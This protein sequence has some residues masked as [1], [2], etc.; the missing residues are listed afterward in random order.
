VSRALRGFDSVDPVIRQHVLDVASRLDYVASPAA[1]ALSTGK[2]GSIGIITPFVDRLAFLR[3]LKGIESEMRAANMDLLLHCTGDPSDPHPVPPHKRLARRVDGFLV[4]SVS[5]ESPDL[6][7][8]LKL[9]MPVTIFGST[10]PRASSINIDDRAGAAS[11]VEHLLERGHQRIGVIYGREL[12][13]P[14]VLEHQRYL[15]CLDA[16]KRAGLP[17]NDRLQ[18]PGDYTIAG[19]ERAMTQLLD[20][21]EPLTAVFAF[22]DEMAFGAIQAM[23]KRGVRPGRDIAIIG[24]DGHEISAVLDLSTISV[25]FELIGATAAHDLLREL[26]AP[27]EQRTAKVFPTELIARATTSQAS[28]G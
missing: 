18:V 16:M 15:G 7:G 2:A 1:A 19:G 5:A 25:P 27:T 21:D 13:N 17:L 20:S 3:M 11:A 26:G 23:K 8:I 24:Y 14:I 6:E 4:L 10:G 9:G 12:D 22:S 28:V